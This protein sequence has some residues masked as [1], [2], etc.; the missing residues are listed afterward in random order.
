MNSLLIIIQATRQDEPV[1]FTNTIL[2]SIFNEA[3]NA[4]SVKVL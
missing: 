2:V 1:S 3:R 4:F